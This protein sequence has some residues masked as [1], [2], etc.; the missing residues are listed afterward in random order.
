MTRVD[1]RSTMKRRGQTLAEFALTLPILLLLIF[2]IIE[3]GR[4]FQA[5]VTLQNSARAA[6]RYATT[7]QY[8]ET[9]YP[10]QLN[11][12]PPQPA[13]GGSP[14]VPAGDPNSVVPCVGN[15]DISRSVYP[16]DQRGTRI[17]NF[18]PNGPGTETFDIYTGGIESIFATWNGGQDCDPLDPEHQNL[19]K[20]MVRILSIIDEA[21]RGAVG[22]GLGPNPIPEPVRGDTGTNPEL[23]PW[24]HVWY[25]PLPGASVFP[26]Q[27]TQLRGSDRPGWFDVMICS[28]RIK[29]KAG[30]EPDQRNPL[31]RRFLSLPPDAGTDSR[32]PVC[33]LQEYPP[34]G[35]QTAAEGWTNNFNRPWLDAGGPGDTVN[36]VVTFNHPLVTPLGIAPF[37]PLQARRTAVNESFRAPRAAPISGSLPDREITFRTPTPTDTPA[38]PGAT[39][40]PTNT[41]T[42]TNTPLPTSTASSTPTNTATPPPV[43]DCSFVSLDS[44]LQLSNNQVSFT[45][46]NNYYLPLT[47][48]RVS[49]NWV[50]LSGYPG[51]GVGTM[52]LSSSVIYNPS[53]IDTSPAT[54]AGAPVSEGPFVTGANLTIPA[55]TGPGV[56]GTI[57]VRATFFNGPFPLSAGL[58]PHHFNGTVITVIFQGTECPLTFNV[59][60]PAATNTPS[61]TPDC[62]V[63]PLRISAVD[64]ALGSGIARFFI[65]NLGNTP[66]TVVG[67]NIN[68]TRFGSMALW[69]VSGGGATLGTSLLMWQFAPSSG[70]TT[71]PTVGGQAPFTLRKGRGSTI[72]PS[73]QA[74]RASRS[75]SSSSVWGRRRCR[76]RSRA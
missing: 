18:T 71:P 33:L 43:F 37:L 8:D 39:N 61:P 56:P 27:Y 55:A 41:H 20:D 70:D 3:F 22:L 5:W 72:S 45:I 67:M 31:A 63:S 76:R 7:G 74:A 62:V 28:S 64:F 52:F 23:V 12:F 36:I 25:R 49:L 66:A 53:S 15:D 58:Q 54:I 40:T 1:G 10:L 42:A 30:H 35:S 9:R 57:P 21:R 60:P 69:R 38:V 59:T 29:L 14:A 24:Y 50:T 11:Y 13:S 16:S 75:M 34:L 46:R 51:M 47:L 17:T 2:G 48:H 68:W 19:R 44:S 65:T 6:A 32:M 26:P 73:R 4:I